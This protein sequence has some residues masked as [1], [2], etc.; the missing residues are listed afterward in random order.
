[1]ARAI[2]QHEL[3]DPD[4]SWLI[5]NFRENRGNVLVVESSCLPVVLIMG[6]PEII[7]EVAEE[8]YLGGTL[9]THT[10]EAVTAEDKTPK[11][12]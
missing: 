7:T 1:M 4:F 3:T 9:N 10:A 12:S 2:Y 11:Q 5:N 6:N 8:T